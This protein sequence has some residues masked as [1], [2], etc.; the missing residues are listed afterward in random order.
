M[1]SAD[2]G[3]QMRS[4]QPNNAQ[5]LMRIQV[6]K[7]SVS[8]SPS[9]IGEEIKQLFKSNPDGNPFQI[10]LDQ[11]HLDLTNVVHERQQMIN[12]LTQ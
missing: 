8:Q 11:N 5:N 3:S 2:T 10:L 12:R 6:N 4:I 7:S 9:Q 1:L